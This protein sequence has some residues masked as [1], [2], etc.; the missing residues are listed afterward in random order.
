MAENTRI[1][2][3]DDT[4]NVA[5]GCTEQRLISGRMD[6]ACVNCYARLMSVRSEAMAAE[7]GRPTVYEGVAERTQGHGARWTGVLRM[8]ALD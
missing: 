3:A 5:G 2:W 7:A 8:R 1:E 6:P 4:V